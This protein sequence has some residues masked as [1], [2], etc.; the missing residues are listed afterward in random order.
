MFNSVPWACSRAGQWQRL[1]ILFPR[2]T[3]ILPSQAPTTDPGLASP[4][5]LWGPPDP[6]SRSVSWSKLPPTDRH[7]VLTGRVDLPKIIQSEG[8][9]QRLKP[10]PSPANLTLPFI[11][12]KIDPPPGGTGTA[13][14]LRGAGTP[15][16]VESSGQKQLQQLVCCVG[17]ISSICLIK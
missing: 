4:L 5:P 2:K 8:A 7:P 13:H 6:G 11:S 10:R 12:C 9:G 16:G 1:H 17:L 3:P 15:L 14:W